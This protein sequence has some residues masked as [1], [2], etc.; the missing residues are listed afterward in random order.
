MI[1][2]L[3]PLIRKFLPF[4]QERMGFDKPPRLFLKNDSSN[5]SNPLGRTAFYD[6]SNKSVTLYVTGR[7]PKDVMRSLSHELVHHTQNCRGD[8]DNVGEMEEGYAQSDSHLRE[9]EREAYEVGNMCF[10]DWEDSVKSTIYYEHLQKGEKQMSTKD[11]KNGELTTVL[12]EAFGFKFN[13][14]N[15]NEGGE[16]PDYIDIDGDGDKE[17]SMKDAAADKKEKSVDENAFAPNH[18]C[19]HHG[20][21]SR[22]GSVELAEAINHNYDTELGR[23]THYDMKFADG[24]IMENVAAEDIQVT[25]ASLEED[26]SHSVGKRDDDEDL[27][28][29]NTPPGPASMVKDA[30][31]GK[32]DDEEDLDEIAQLAV[33]AGKLAGAAKNAVGAAKKAGATVKKGAKAVEDAKELA[34]LAKDSGELD[35]GGAAARVGNEEKDQGRDRMHA[36]R[37][38]ENDTAEPSEALKEAILNILKKHF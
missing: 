2:T 15:L 18:Y 17:E 9:M 16:K 28:E 35:E 5:A 24:T 31:L 21:V 4:A 25:N 6:P 19:V 7:H 32:R 33:G 14:N 3:K 29:I 26:H 34:Q 36:D 38:H 20:G 22:N 30:A 1:D 13:L 23:V 10:R 8:F 12:S 27:E 37:V 11:W